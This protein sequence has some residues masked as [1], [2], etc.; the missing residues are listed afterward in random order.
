M[1]RQ[2]RDWNAKKTALEKDIASAE[3]SNSMLLRYGKNLVQT[4][5]ITGDEKELQAAGLTGSLHRYR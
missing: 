3:G 5:A 4:A 2:L 1:Q